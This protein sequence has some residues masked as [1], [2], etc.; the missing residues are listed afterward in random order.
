MKRMKWLTLGII[1]TVIIVCLYYFIPTTVQIHQTAAIKV[2]AKAFSRTISDGEKWQQWWP[3]KKLPG[4]HFPTY[5]LD[6][7]QYSIIDRKQYS[8]VVLI[9]DN[10]ES[11]ATE[12]N[13]FPLTTDSIAI[14]WKGQTIPYSSIFTRINNYKKMIKLNKQ[15]K[16]ILEHIQTFYANEDNIYTMHIRKDHVSDSML[17][18]TSFISREYPSVENIYMLIDQL[19]E[20]AVKGS[21]KQTGYPMLNIMHTDSSYLT[22]V[23]IP[24]DKKIK[25]SG[26]MVYRWMLGRGNILVTEV[27]GG[28]NTI[29]K[30]FEELDN[31]IADHNRAAPAIPF[32]SLITNRRE[33]PDSG[34]WITNVFWPVM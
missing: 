16:S 9:K 6:N 26:N 30:A 3:G 7:Y 21:A 28:P 11:M 13:I 1:I 27:I 32:Q 12:M 19:K 18:S 22:R 29:N 25:D 8:V 31:Y 33:N 34:K 20:F 17:I 24:I 4:F 23:A 2:N 5:E 14:I 15:V 10:I